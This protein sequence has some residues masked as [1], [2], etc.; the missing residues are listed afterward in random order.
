MFADRLQEQFPINAVEVTPHVDI[1][2]PVVPPASLTGLPNCVNRRP[3]RSIS[4]G[5]FMEDRFQDGLQVPLDDFLGNP[6][7]D[8]RN[9]QWSGFCLAIAL[10]NIDPP[11]RWRKVAP[12]SQSVPELVEVVRKSS[13]KVRNRLPIYS[14]RP[15]VG[16]HFLESLPDFPLRDVERLCLVHRAPP[17]TS[18]L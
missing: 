3:A 17:V 4:I 11:N 13:L 5:A 7:R 6:V 1:E 8:R 9:P 14:S 12:R 2:H 15:L 18:W 10:R 16:L